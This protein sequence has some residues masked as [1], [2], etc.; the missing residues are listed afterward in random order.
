MQNRR[1]CRYVYF[2]VFSLPMR[3]LF[4]YSEVRRKMSEIIYY[5]AYGSNLLRERFLIYIKG[6]E[7]RGKEYRG[8]RDKTE[9]IDMGWIYVPLQALFCKM[10]STMGK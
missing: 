7:Y 3:D 1:I 10:F 9:P 5:G 4:A 8:C 6:G 2:V